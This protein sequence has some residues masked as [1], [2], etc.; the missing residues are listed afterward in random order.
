MNVCLVSAPIATDFKRRDE[1]DSCLDEPAVSEP[2]LGVLSL[3]AVLEARRDAARIIDLDQAYL[4]YLDS[5]NQLCSFAAVVAKFL[6]DDP[7]DIYGFSTICSSYPLTI[8]IARAVKAARPES[9]VLLGGPQA[10]VV[11]RQTLAAFPFIDFVLRGESENTLPLLLDE[12]GGERQLSRVPS[13]TYRCGSE[14]RRNASAPIIEDLDAIPSPAYHLTGGLQGATKASLELGRGCPF[15]CTFCSTNDFFRRRFRLRSPER[16]IR[17]M[18]QI[19]NTYGIRQ[20]ELVHDMF[21]VD[22]RRVASFCEAMLASGEGFEW[23][24][25]ART[26]CVDEKL[27]DHMARAGCVG[28]FY[29]VESGSQRLQKVFDKHLDVEQARHVIAATE[30]FDIRSTVSLITGFPEETELD[31]RET[32]SMFI[33]SARHSQSTPHL[34]ILAP[35]AET[36]IHLKFRDQMT[37]GDLC[38]DISQQGPVQDPEDWNL[39]ELHPEIFPNFYL[40]PTPHLDRGRLLELREF[41]LNG[42]GHFRWLLCAIDQTTQELYDLFLLWQKHRMEMHPIQNG[43]ELKRYYNSS[44]FR[45]DFLSFVQSSPAAENRIVSV[46]LEFEMA[47]S[48]TSGSSAHEAIASATAPNDGAICATGV[49]LRSPGINLVELSCDI[50][51][52]INALKHGAEPVWDSGPHSYMTLDSSEALKRLYAISRELG[53]LLQLCDGHHNLR[54]I[55]SVLTHEFADVEISH[56][57]AAAVT[58]IEAAVHEGLVSIQSANSSAHVL[59]PATS[60]RTSIG[61]AAPE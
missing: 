1:I 54:E 18:R 10:T 20:F 19:A 11:D 22:R 34:N 16:V 43:P 27:L 51:N 60:A 47:W 5:P 59:I 12:L 14:L 58:L 36:P 46:L 31:L 17:D 3:A 52:V 40:L 28:I 13:L 33:F 8:R 38:S 29:G 53:R 37:L 41:A 48:S 25:S 2:Q 57:E 39:I 7:A 15:A 21:T 42:L 26:D 55:V 45:R 30:H 6:A 56:R 23:S 24:C 9:L 50:Q 35:L 49:P 32:L 44:S 61:P 4:A